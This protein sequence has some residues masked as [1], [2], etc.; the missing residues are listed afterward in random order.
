MT[1]C[2][3]DN[4]ETFTAVAVTVTMLLLIMAL[5]GYSDTETHEKAALEYL[6]PD[7]CSCCAEF[8]HGIAVVTAVLILLLSFGPRHHH[9]PIVCFLLPVA[10]DCIA[11]VPSV[12][13][14]I[15]LTDAPPSQFSVIAFI[16]QRP[17]PNLA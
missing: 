17:P 1:A 7:P 12:R 3:I 6:R 9:A 4:P 8:L 13:R 16:F 15:F 5:V 11:Y 14:R 10:F 2:Q